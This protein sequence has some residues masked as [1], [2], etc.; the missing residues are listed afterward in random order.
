MPSYSKY[1]MK[2]L[3]NEARIFMPHVCVIPYTAFGVLCLLLLPRLDHLLIMLMIPEPC[4]THRPCYMINFFWSIPHRFFLNAI[5]WLG[6]FHKTCHQWQMTVFVITY[7]NPRF[8]LVISEFVADFFF[9]FFFFWGGG[10]HLS[11]KKGFM[12]GPRTQLYL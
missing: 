7:W 4:R 12:N 5:A 6:A 3:R 9:F 2:Q 8:W 11:L 10:G 1:D